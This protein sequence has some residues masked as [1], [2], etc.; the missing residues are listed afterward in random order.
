MNPWP[1]CEADTIHCAFKVATKI[2]TDT[3]VITNYI[4][5][6]TE[7]HTLLVAAFN[8]FGIK[9]FVYMSLCNVKFNILIKRGHTCI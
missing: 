5:L 8:S 2:T 6:V 1:V 7:E 9:I 3:T 4:S